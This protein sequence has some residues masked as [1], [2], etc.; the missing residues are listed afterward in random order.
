MST[1]QPRIVGV[2]IEGGVDQ[3]RILA[4]TLCQR[5]FTPLVERLGEEAKHPAG[6]RDG[7]PQHAASGHP[8]VYRKCAQ[9]SRSTT[10]VVTRQGR[11]PTA[12]DAA[13][14][15]HLMKREGFTGNPPYSTPPYSSRCGVSNRVESS[16]RRGWVPRGPLMKMSSS[17]ADCS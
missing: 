14:V 6:H 13:S 5:R 15:I 12:G 17:R 11:P 16:T 7:T 2:D 1:P 10:V 8:A 4:V 3:M 9:I